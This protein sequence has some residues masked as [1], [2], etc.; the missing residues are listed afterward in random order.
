MDHYPEEGDY[1]DNSDN[2]DG[3][4]GGAPAW[5]TSS[6]RLSLSPICQMVQ[7]VTE[8]QIDN[9]PETENVTETDTRTE[10]ETDNKTQ[11]LRIRH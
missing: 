2:G 1:H 3:A 7:T 9:E 6:R 5:L 4:E 11:R 8:T 10:T